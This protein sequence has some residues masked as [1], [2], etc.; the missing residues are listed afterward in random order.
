[1]AYQLAYIAE[2]LEDGAR[3]FQ[4]RTAQIRR[5]FWWQNCKVRLS[6]F[7]QHWVDRNMNICLL[8]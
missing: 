6:R 8:I 7:M 5:K 1:M 3:Q 4:S 2:N